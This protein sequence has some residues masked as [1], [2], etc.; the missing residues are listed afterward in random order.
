MAW[1]SFDRVNSYN[2]FYH[3][4]LTNRG[5]GKSYGAKKRCIDRFLKYGEQFV[6]VRRY[7]TELKK[8]SRYFEDIK[9]RYKGHDLEVRGRTFY[10]DGKVCGYAIPL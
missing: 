8:I 7:K 1:Y 6:Y 9:E 10:C 5:F 2:S 4:I 3:F